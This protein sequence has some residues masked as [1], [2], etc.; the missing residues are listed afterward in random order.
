[1][2]RLLEGCTFWTRKCGGGEVEWLSTVEVTVWPLCSGISIVLGWKPREKEREGYPLFFFR[3]PHS[4]KWTHSFFFFFVTHRWLL[5]SLLNLAN[6]HVYY[7]W[8]FFLIMLY[9][10]QNFK[11]VNIVRSIYFTKNICSVFFFFFHHKSFC[12]ILVKCFTKIHHR[13]LLIWWMG[14]Q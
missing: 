3:Y 10:L 11:N 12:N 14:H 9:Q 7:F 8:Y 1:M 2:R 6:W 5:L 13:S 4:V